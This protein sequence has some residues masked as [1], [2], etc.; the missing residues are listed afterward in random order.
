[1]QSSLINRT[2]RTEHAVL[3]NIIIPIHVY[4]VITKHCIIELNINLFSL[5]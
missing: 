2:C 3:Y 4:N 5:S 1:M